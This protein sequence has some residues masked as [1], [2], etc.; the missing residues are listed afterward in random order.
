[1]FSC[2]VLIWSAPDMD[3]DKCDWSKAYLW[4]HDFCFPAKNQYA[5]RYK[6][7]TSP[8]KYWTPLLWSQR[9]T[10][11]D[12]YCIRVLNFTHTPL[13]FNVILTPKENIQLMFWQSV[14]SERNG[15]LFIYIA[16]YTWVYFQ[17]A[18]WLFIICQV[19]SIKFS[20]DIHGVNK[21]SFYWL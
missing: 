12:W 7:N 18:E 15:C 9:P 13:C 2:Y 17:K 8:L 14:V 4:K 6:C 3:E 11:N 21:V 20:G 16:A 19:L 5:K 10:W 1:M